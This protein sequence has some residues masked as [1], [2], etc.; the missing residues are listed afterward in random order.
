MLGL[1]LTVG[2]GWGALALGYSG[3]H[4][5]T[6]R[7]LLAGAFSLAS[8]AALIALAVRRWRWRALAAWL[9]LFAALLAWYFSIEPSNERDWQ[10]DVAVLPYATIE[11]A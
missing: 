7:R 4:S 6:V 9:G 2:G 5:D 3:P 8:L 1:L 11:G 10:S